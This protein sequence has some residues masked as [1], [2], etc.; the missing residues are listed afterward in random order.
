MPT[1][2]MNTPISDWGLRLDSVNSIKN[3]EQAKEILGA[4]FGSLYWAPRFKK[5]GYKAKIS[6]LKKIR[7]LILKRMN[8][9]PSRTDKYGNTM[10]SDFV[11]SEDGLY[12]ILRKLGAI[13]QAWNN[14]HTAAY[15]GDDIA[16]TYCEGDIM[17][18]RGIKARY[19]AL[20]AA[21]FWEDEY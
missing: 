15:Y 21:R 16:V 4:I 7:R 14:G 1:I 11:F 5:E 8:S 13:N 3:T 17:I 18:Y 9:L 10:E 2:T 20:D 19:A 6:A 12:P